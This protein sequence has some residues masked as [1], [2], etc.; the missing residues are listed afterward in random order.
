[1][2]RARVA[3]SVWKVTCNSRKF[4]C[5]ILAGMKIFGVT[6]VRSEADI[7]AVTLRYHLHLGLEEILVID[8]ASSDGTDQILER[9]AQA[10]DRIRWSRHEGEYKQAELLTGL[11][12]DAFRAGAD[13]IVPF[14]ADEFWYAP[15]RGF[16]EV[17]ASSKAGALRAQV[18]HYIQAR[19]QLEGSPEALL[20]MM[21]RAPRAIGPPDHGRALVE[22]R[23]IGYV[24]AMYSPKWISRASADLRIG[25]GNHSATNLAGAPETTIELLCL[26]APIRSRQKLALKAAWSRRLESAG[27]AQEDGWHCR[28]AQRLVEEDSIDAEW[29][30]NSYKEDALDVYGSRRPVVFDPTL[31]NAVEPF[32]T[33][34]PNVLLGQEAA[35][36]QIDREDW[37]R[38]MG[39]NF[40]T[41]LHDDALARTEWA[42]GLDKQLVRARER[43]TDLEG[44]VAESTA[45]AKALDE[46][47]VAERA[48]ISELEKR[49]VE[50]TAWA[51]SLEEEATETRTHCTALEAQ[52]AE[53]TAWAQSLDKEVLETRT[54]CTALEGQIAERTAWAQSLDKEVL[55]TRTHC[56][57]LEAQIA[58]RTVWAQSLDNEVLETRTHYAALEARIMERTDWA[59]SLDREMSEMRANHAA[60]EAQM[61]E[62]TAWAQSLEKELAETRAHGAALEAQIAERTHWAQSLEK[63]LAE[64]RAHGAALEAQVAERTNWARAAD[65]QAERARAALANL[66]AEL[67]ERRAW[68]LRLAHKLERARGV[69][70]PTRPLKS[71]RA[72]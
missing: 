11:A 52:I 10:D 50:R 17:L 72:V 45:W 8:N 40:L 22:E 26:H 44:Q 6:L 65:T 15:C 18:V 21:G 30:A 33:R 68:A 20:G 49:V 67:G 46:Q 47:L 36:K 71:A 61:A 54:H 35:D 39:Q 48:V 41:S 43:L 12:Q 29:A 58:E 24:E 37:Q 42:V 14:D 66:Q 23:K 28:R 59:R 1:M 25:A 9:M 4:H 31:R 27:W 60:L 32:V 34:S 3:K 57:A 19:E 63:E 38:A 5:T 70:S 56:T 16:R 13:W 53:R 2:R 51:Q 7:I 55:E 69:G 62:R 64:T